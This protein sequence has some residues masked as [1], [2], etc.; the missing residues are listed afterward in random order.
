[1]TRKLIYI[2][3]S[4]VMGIVTLL[5]VMLVIAAFNTKKNEA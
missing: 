5:V 2:M 1:M 3:G 4:A